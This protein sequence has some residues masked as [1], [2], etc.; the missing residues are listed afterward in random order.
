MY[1]AVH[2]RLVLPPCAQLDIIKQAHIEV[3][4]MGSVKTMRNVQESFVWP[5]MLQ[6][7]NDYIAK[8]PTCKY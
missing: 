2:P 5:R 1:A 3:G 4:H 8:W 6:T 7:I